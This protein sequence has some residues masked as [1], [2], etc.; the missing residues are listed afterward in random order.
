VADF[1]TLLRE[2]DKRGGLPAEIFVLEIGVGTGTRAA[3]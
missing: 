1:W 3:L 2:L